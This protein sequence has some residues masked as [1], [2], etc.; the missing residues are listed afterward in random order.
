MVVRLAKRRLRQLLQES[1]SV[2]YSECK[3]DLHI[4]SFTAPSDTI[5][6]AISHY[7]NCLLSEGRDNKDAK[8]EVRRDG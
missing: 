3:Y 4:S 5:S 1:K 2:S 6:E 8:E 7:L